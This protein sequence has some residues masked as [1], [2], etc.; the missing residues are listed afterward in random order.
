MIAM[1]RVVIVGAGISGLALAYRLQQAAPQIET[2]VLEERARPGGNIW[3]EELQG[4]RVEFGPNG[5]LD[6]KPST[7]QLCRDLGLADR[8]VPSSD[9]ARRNRYVFVG[10]KLHA[11][12]SSPV[13]LAASGVLSWRGKWGLL[14]E[15]LRRPRRLDHDESIHSFIARRGGR[16]VADTLGKAFVTGIFAGDPK[17]LSVRACLPRLVALEQEHGSV[18]RGFLARARQRRKQAADAGGPAPRPSAM[19]SFREGLRLL[20]E[21]LA[22]QLQRPPL[23]GV[24]IRRLSR[25]EQGWQVCAEGKESWSADALV[26]TCPAYRQ[27]ALLAEVDCELADLVHGIAY[28]RVAVVALGYRVADLPKPLNGF[29]FLTPQSDQLD[30]LGAQWCSSIYPDRAPEGMVLLRAMCGGWNRPEVPGWDDERLLAAV[31]AG[32]RQTM[33]ITAPPVFHHIVRWDRAIP[34]YLLG[35]LER[36]AR[37]E[38]L[39]A[40]HQGLFLAGNAYRGVAMNDCTEQAEILAGRITDCLEKIAGTRG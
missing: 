20:V 28:N 4:F 9:A 12:P 5:F 22:E 13:G 18:I 25:G 34:Q 14:A 6:T 21:T 39:S 31:R 37:I 32:L 11:L 35:H 19:W 17:L 1:Q 29:G 40:G 26:L 33:R 8:L 7:L 3:T 38:K 27:A 10:G 15:T 30:L 16:E 2:T 23:L 24:P 36:V